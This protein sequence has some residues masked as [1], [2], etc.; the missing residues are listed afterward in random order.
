MINSKFGRKIAAM[1]EHTDFEQV[2]VD[3]IHYHCIDVPCCLTCANGENFDSEVIL[4]RANKYYNPE[5]GAAANWFGD[6]LGLCDNYKKIPGS[7]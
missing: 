7:T 6:H 2:L 1:E 5:M 3:K 4:C